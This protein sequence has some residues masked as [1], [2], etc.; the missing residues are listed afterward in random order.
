MGWKESAVCLFSLGMVHY[1]VFCRAGTGF[2]PCC[3]RCFSCS[4]PPL[5]LPAWRGSPLS[6]VSIRRRRC[7][8]FYPS[9]SSLL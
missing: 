4:S 1:L 2:R 7:S 8:S 5:A 3:G 6:E 9:S